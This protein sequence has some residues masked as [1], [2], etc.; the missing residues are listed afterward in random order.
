MVELAFMPLK[1]MIE[2][3]AGEHLSITAVVLIRSVF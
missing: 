1:G 2:A 3:I